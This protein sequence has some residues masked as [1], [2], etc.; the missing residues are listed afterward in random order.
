M[1]TKR[2]VIVVITVAACFGSLHA[3]DWG[4]PDYVPGQE[5]I[6]IR[7][8]NL[9]NAVT[10]SSVPPML[11]V[12]FYNSSVGGTYLIKWR[13][14]NRR[15]FDAGGYNYNGQAHVVM[16]PNGP[17][18][19]KYALPAFAAED[20]YS[21]EISVYSA[22][23][24]FITKETRDFDL[25]RRTQVDQPGAD[26]TVQLLSIGNKEIEPGKIATV[27]FQVKNIGMAA[28][29]PSMAQIQIANPD[30]GPTQATPYSTGNRPDPAPQRV[31][32]GPPAI[33][34]V[35][36]SVPAL[37]PGETREVSH[38]FIFPA[39]VKAALKQDPTDPRFLLARIRV[40]VNTGTPPVTESSTFNNVDYLQVR[41]AAPDYRQMTGPRDTM[42]SLD[43]GQVYAGRDSTAP[44]VLTYEKGYV[45]QGNRA[46]GEPI[47]T[48]INNR[49]YLGRG[50]SG[51]L[52]G[53]YE[54]EALRPMPT[55]PD[56]PVKNYPA[57][58][59]QTESYLIKKN[60]NEVAIGNISDGLYI[61]ESN[62]PS[63]QIIASYIG[64]D[65]AGIAGL[66][67]YFLYPEELKRPDIRPR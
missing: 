61:R 6:K 17:T 20:R 64:N 46:Q 51:K 59:A 15:T 60:L 13:T 28:A 22:S 23:G 14:F 5:K 30:A 26:L 2:I 29:P 34:T 1:I 55:R 65:R 32:E 24:Q 50:T 47:M 27:R 9:I 67:W 18:S 39:N 37:N 57:V 10:P 63:G 40:K 49:I 25:P 4:D 62:S 58:R 12:Q 36:V 54:A 11:E 45:Y 53:Y 42:T 7:S 3:R 38:S 66:A 35:N 21:V 16:R 43:Y 48:I 41:V 33:H 31:V 19:W 8:I 56:S 44:I 52:L